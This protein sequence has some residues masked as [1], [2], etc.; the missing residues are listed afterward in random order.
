MKKLQIRKYKIPQY[1][2]PLRLKRIFMD[3]T[4]MVGP[5]G[6]EPGTNRL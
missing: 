3:Y 5:P 6:I 4:L 1:K 2:N